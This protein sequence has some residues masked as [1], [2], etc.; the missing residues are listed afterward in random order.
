[1]LR[2]C[3]FLVLLCTAVVQAQAV[4]EFKAL[5]GHTPGEQ[6]TPQAA[7]E[8]WVRAAA[9]ASPR[10]RLVEYG[11]T[12]EGRALLLVVVSAEANH[13]H[14]QELRTRHALL[15]SG[16]ADVDI[17]A[18]VQGLPAVVWLSYTVH[19]DEASGSEAALLVLRRL[20]TATD[21]ETVRWLRDTIII[22]DPCLNPD[23]RDRYV[24][25]FRSVQGIAP[26]VDVHT[27]EHDQ[28]WPGGRE[29]H[30]YFDLNRDWAFATQPETRARLPHFVAWQPQVHADLHEM[31]YRSTYFFF[32]AEKPINIHLPEHTMKWGRLFGEGN[33]RAFDERGWPYYTAED[34]DLFY[35]GYGDSWPS[36]HGAIGMTYEQAGGGRAGSAV[37]LP[38]GRVLTLADRAA[39][40]ELASYS[41]IATAATRRQ[42]LLTDYAMFR[43]TALEEGRTGAVRSFLLAPGQDPGALDALVETLQLQGISVQCASTAF[44]AEKV[45]DALGGVVHDRTFEVGTCIVDLAQ[46]A[47]RLAKTLLE[48]RTVIRELFFYDISAWSLP[49]AHGVQVYES[50]VL[51]SVPLHMKDELLAPAGGCPEAAP[52]VGWLVRYGTRGAVEALVALLAEGVRVKSAH[53][54]FLLGDQFFARGTLLLRRDENAVDVRATLDRIGRKHHVVFM[55]VD[56]GFTAQGIDLGSVSITPI[57]PPRIALLGGEDFSETSFGATRH[58]LDEVLHAPLSVFTPDRFLAADHARYSAVVLPEGRVSDKLKE[59]LQRFA[60]LG[61][62]V[63]AMGDSAFALVPKAEAAAGK[64]TPEA[65]RRRWIEEREAEERRLQQ[66]GSVFRVELDPAHPLSFGYR[67]ELSAFKA[68]VRALD[69]ALAGTHV[70]LFKEAAEVS[71]YVAPEHAKALGGRAYATVLDEGQGA[72]VLFA[73]DPNFRGAWRGLT[74]MFMNAVLLLPTRHVMRN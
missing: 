1:M 72:I 17:A 10:A 55:P 20:L 69:P 57:V 53:K 59:A 64:P 70:A 5:I 37:R 34:F 54:E 13:E 41:T 4:P 52:K 19:G 58:L 40:H 68:G 3:V 35:P 38:D 18:N 2:V 46:P 51:P 56:S 74:R 39:H 25:W 73:D 65:P 29:N 21:E 45:K 23:G 36:L 44:T 8:V 61:G 71:G 48:P 49:L 26:D 30:W 47:Q 50:P 12:P 42:E 9:A 28:P 63:V 14:M 67:S 7:L 60:R 24:Q 66:P 16:R 11:R 43:R 33:A 32:P 6:F 22:I 15:A 31:S 62:V 27:A